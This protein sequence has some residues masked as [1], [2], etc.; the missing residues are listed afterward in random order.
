MGNDMKVAGLKLERGVVLIEALLAAVVLAVGFLALTALE[1]RI[2]LAI[3]GDKARAEAMELAKDL[4]EELAILVVN[5]EFET[6]LSDTSWNPD[7]TEEIEGK[8]A[9]FTPRWRITDATSTA[10]GAMAFLEVEVN[11][12]DSKGDTQRVMLVTN[13]ASKPLYASTATPQS[14]YGQVSSPNADAAEY[15]DPDSITLPESGD[16]TYEIVRDEQTIEVDVKN[17]FGDLDGDGVDDTIVWQT[18]SDGTI[19]VLGIY[20]EPLRIQGRV[21]FDGSID[22]IYVLTSDAG[23]C[24]FPYEV[25]GPTDGYNSAEYTCYVGAGWRGKVGVIGFTSATPLLCPYVS[26]M[27][28]KYQ[29][30][31]GDGIIDGHTGITSEY[32]YDATDVEDGFDDNHNFLVRDS[33]SGTPTCSSETTAVDDSFAPALIVDNTDDEL[34]G[35]NVYTVTGTF[36]KRS[37]A[38]DSDAVISRVTEGVDADGNTIFA[39]SDLASCVEGDAGGDDGLW[40]CTVQLPLDPGDTVAFRVQSNGDALSRIDV[41]DRLD[42]VTLADGYDNTNFETTVFYFDLS[43]LATNVAVGPDITI[44]R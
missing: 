13:I 31:D 3:S 25:S 43:G 14:G 34:S 17:D 2:T 4:S 30:D 9:V 35:L 7:V 44:R 37:G 22:D 24:A 18:N 21:Y 8:N 39:N 26:R 11:W 27:Y 6:L 41:D 19:T 42:E 29:D 28:V 5:N 38:T 33:N 40:T 36:T 16:Q 23:L 15:L 10:L 20:T 1:G 12:A 32:L